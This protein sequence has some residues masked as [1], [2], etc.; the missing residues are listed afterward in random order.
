MGKRSSGRGGSKRNNT[1]GNTKTRVWSN[2]DFS[3]L[4]AE[5]KKLG[6]WIEKMDKDGNC[7]FHSF[8]DQVE[9][10]PQCHEG[11]RRDCVAYMTAHRED[12]E[13]FI[14]DDSSFEDYMKEMAKDGTWGTQ[15]ELLALCHK[16]QVNAIVHQDSDGG[17]PSYEIEVVPP[18]HQC[19]MLSFH[20]GEHYNSVRFLKD[21]NPQNSNR[22]LV[23]SPVALLTLSDLRACIDQQ[24]DIGPQHRHQQQH[25][26]H[27]QHQPLTLPPSELEATAEGESDENLPRGGYDKNSE[28][29]QPLVHREKKSKS[30]GRMCSYIGKL[31]T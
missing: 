4:A 28:A 25:H 6:L 20:D 24:N 2:S 10:R 18:D 17:K 14:T 8:A 3:M 21:R 11:Y 23:A 13:A 9:G 26:D 27:H 5:L 19:V 1:T 7:L 22:A 30:V 12:F 16:F 29:V 15:L 31:N